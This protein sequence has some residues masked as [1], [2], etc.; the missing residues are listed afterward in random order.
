MPQGIATISEEIVLKTRTF[1]LFLSIMFV[2]L[3]LFIL[4]YCYSDIVFRV[5]QSFAH[6]KQGGILQ[7]SG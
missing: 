7:N 1:S 4:H 5:V 3:W 6:N 2:Y